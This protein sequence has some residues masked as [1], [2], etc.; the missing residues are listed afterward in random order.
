MKI[1]ELYFKWNWVLML[2]F[3]ALS[4][5][6]YRFGLMAILCIVPAVYMAVKTKNKTFCAYSCPRGSFLT[7]MLKNIHRDKKIPRFIFS[8]KFRNTF[9]VIMFSLFGMSL[10]KT[11]GNLMK[12][13]F[14]FFR[15]IASSTVI[16][17][18]LG[19]LYKPRTWCQVCPL[20]QGTKLVGKLSENLETKTD[21]KE[22]V[23]MKKV[24]GIGLV[25]GILASGVVLAEDSDWKAGTGVMKDGGQGQYFV[26]ENNDGINDNF[27]DENGD[28][29]NDEPRGQGRGIEDG[30]RGNRKNSEDREDNRGTGQGRNFESRD[31]NNDSRRGNKQGRGQGAGRGSNGKGRR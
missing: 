21:K 12:V 30:T 1:K 8:E 28:G 19:F 13:G 16:G 3:L 7:K 25:V 27:I 17:L 20:G 26:D 5:L 24:I 31:G 14:V 18:V 11:D 2:V 23:V 15:F 6:D 4:V 29:L 9:F 10:F 22:M